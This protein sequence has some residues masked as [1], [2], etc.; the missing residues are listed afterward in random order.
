[1]EFI[2]VFLP[3]LLAAGKEINF[4]KDDNF[5]MLVIYSKYC[6]CINFILLL[7]LNIIGKSNSPFTGWHTVLFYT[8]YMIISLVLAEFLPKTFEFIR[9]NF[10]IK[11]RR[12]NK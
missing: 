6:L 9:K 8:F 7:I 10:D 4:K 2:C 3:A 11:I 5:K 12:I 1:M